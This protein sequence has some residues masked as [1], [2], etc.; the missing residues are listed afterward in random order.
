MARFAEALA[1]TRMTTIRELEIAGPF[2][3]IRAVL[4][5]GVAG[6]P[7]GTWRT[8]EAMACSDRL[9]GRLADM[10][11]KDN[12]TQASP[13]IEPRCVESVGAR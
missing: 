6:H 10:Q 2:F 12:F 1:Y 7:S 11:G 13:I 4:D 5:F 8:A 9:P 3:A